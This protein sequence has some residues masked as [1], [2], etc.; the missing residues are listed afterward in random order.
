MKNTPKIQETSPIIHFREAA[1]LSAVDLAALCD[2]SPQ[3]LYN[4]ESL[5]RKLGIPE[6][7][8]LVGVFSSKGIEC[9]VDDMY[10]SDAAA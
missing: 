1:D 8:V 10:P 4:Y 2:W 5:N 9:T 3:R 7:R 6:A